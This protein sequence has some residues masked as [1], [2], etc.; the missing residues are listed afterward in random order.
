MSPGAGPRPSRK[1][2]AQT[3]R[4][5]GTGRRGNESDPGDGSHSPLAPGIGVGIGVGLLGPD[6]GKLTIVV[7]CTGT[8]L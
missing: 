6:R 4:L 1:C 2:G 7:L 5:T 8:N 3:P